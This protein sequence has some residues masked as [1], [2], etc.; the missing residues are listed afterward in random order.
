[1]ILISYLSG[2]F[3]SPF[4]AKIL[5]SNVFVSDIASNKKAAESPA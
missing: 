4:M 3:V 1:M 2:N 5:W